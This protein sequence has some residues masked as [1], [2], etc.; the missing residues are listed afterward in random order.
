M[1]SFK[2][3]D[4]NPSVVATSGMTIHS[5]PFLWLLLGMVV[6]VCVQGV[7]LAAVLRCRYFLS[8]KESHEMSLKVAEKSVRALV[9][10]FYN[11]LFFEFSAKNTLPFKL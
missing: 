1:F 6:I 4:S 9:K 10:S 7:M 11:I 2:S 3:V 5:P 8:Q